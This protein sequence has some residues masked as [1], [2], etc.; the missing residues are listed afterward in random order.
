[1]FADQIIT[2]SMSSP[3]DSGSGILDMDRRAAGLLFAGS[4]SVTIFTPIQRVLDYFGVEL[5]M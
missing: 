5:A 2:N 3:G 1:M 4:T